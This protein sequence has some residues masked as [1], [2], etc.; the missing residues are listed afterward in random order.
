MNPSNLYEQDFNAW[1][2][3]QIH[4]LKQGKISELDVTH[5]ITELEDMGKS[6]RRELESRFMI[7]L[8]HLL[9]WQFQLNQLNSQFKEFEGKSWR[10]T[11]IEQRAQILY[12]LDD[13]P[14]LKRELETAILKVYPQA[15]LFAVEET[16]LKKTVFPE[17]CP[18]TTEQLLD[19]QFYP[20]L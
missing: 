1:I 16:G 18:Y 14:S 15:V 10:K 9:K 17:N 6:Q 3:A 20:T 12:L 11:I 8:A 7:L 4:L 13:M 19:K 5:L 2:N